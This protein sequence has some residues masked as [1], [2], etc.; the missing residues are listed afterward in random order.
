[1]LVGCILEAPGYIPGIDL[2]MPSGVPEPSSCFL[3]NFIFHKT[4]AITDLVLP[5]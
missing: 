1:M 5:P 3:L 2:W 4:N